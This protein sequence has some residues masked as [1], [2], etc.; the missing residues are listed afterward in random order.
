MIKALLLSALVAGALSYELPTDQDQMPR[1]VGGED[2]VPNSWPWQVS[3]QY[4]SS[5]QWR[6]TCGGS[7]VAK[8]W[9]LTAAH[10]ISSSRTY[11]V[12]LGKHSLSSV[13]SGSVNVSVSKS[14]VHEKWNSSQLSKGNDIALLKLANSVSLSDKIQLA[15][16]PTAGSI[17]PNNY[18]CY[19]TG[20]GRLQTNG[21]AS[22]ILQQGRLL[23]VDYATC[24]SS[25]WWGSTVKTNMVCAGGDGVVSSC[26][27]D[28]GGPLNCP[29]SN[30]EWEVHGV[31]S[32]G[33]SLGCNYYHKPSVFTRVSNYIDWINSVRTSKPWAPW[34]HPAHLP[35]RGQSLLGSENLLLPSES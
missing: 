30:S 27:G 26:N 14:V 32:F 18:A 17:L 35:P 6:H 23:V 16:L 8:N 9:V 31:V 29:A 25:S 12:A 1:V 3:L 19:V 5:G 11:R 15:R 13:E 33:S 7:L 2:A 34:A 22:D 28:S 21:A 10:C 24:S 20:W 4:S